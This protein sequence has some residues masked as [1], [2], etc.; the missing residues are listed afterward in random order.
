MIVANMRKEQEEQQ[1]S[2]KENDAYLFYAL[3]YGT[4]IQEN[5]IEDNIIDAL[6][7][8]VVEVA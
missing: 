7:V 4:F 1:K 5:S 2:H 3:F 6:M 8:L